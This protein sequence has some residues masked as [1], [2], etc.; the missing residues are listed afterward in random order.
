MLGFLLASQLFMGYFLLAGGQTDVISAA[1][2]C[3]NV[4]LTAMIF[5]YLFSQL[6]LMDLPLGTLVKNSLLLALSFAPRSIAAALIQII[7]WIVIISFL[8]YTA[9]WVVL[10]GFALVELIVLMIIYP[11]MDKCFGLEE[12][13]RQQQAQ[14]D[15]EN[16]ED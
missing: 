8:P 4:L 2:I 11:A 10:F 13:F 14:R 1:L 6:V 5:P 16:R 9:L 3:M 7:Y 15:A 12:R